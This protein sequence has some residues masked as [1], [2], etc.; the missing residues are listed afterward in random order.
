MLV[1]VRHGRIAGAH[2][3]KVS[4]GSEHNLEIQTARADGS[5]LTA[6]KVVRLTGKRAGDAQGKRLGC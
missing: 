5:T 1:T 2:G 6:K 4:P 3:R